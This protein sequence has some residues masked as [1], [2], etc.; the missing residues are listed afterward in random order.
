MRGAQCIRDDCGLDAE[1][2]LDHDQTTGEDLPSNP[3]L[4]PA[5]RLRVARASA[6]R[7]ANEPKAS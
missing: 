7:R 3:A 5:M 1:M 4:A 6:V 2:C